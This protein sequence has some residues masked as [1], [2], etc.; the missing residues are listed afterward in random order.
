MYGSRTAHTFVRIIM[1]KFFTCTCMYKHMGRRTD[2]HVHDMK[3]AHNAMDAR[4]SV[5]GTARGGWTARA[6]RRR[7]RVQRGQAPRHW[8]GEGGEAPD[9]VDHIKLGMQEMHRGR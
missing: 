8:G 5:A 6:S 1:N 4:V 9:S 3:N 2:I 7:L